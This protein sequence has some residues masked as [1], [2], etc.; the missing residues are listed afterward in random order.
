MKKCFF[1]GAT[2]QVK[3]LKEFITD[4]GYELFWLFDN[5]PQVAK[6]VENIPV[7]GG[8]EDFVGWA[9]KNKSKD[10]AFLVAIG[11]DKGKVR[12]ELQSKIQGFGFFPLTVWHK[13][14]Y[15]SSSAKID[16]GSQVLPRATVCVDVKIGKSCIIN[17][18]AQVD[19]ECIIGDG[20]HIM[21]G[22]VLTGCVRV[23]NFATIGSG[24][25]IL[26]RINIGE[27]AI[28]GA[29]AVVTKNVDPYTTV[30]GLPAKVVN[31]KIEKVD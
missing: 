14:S 23:N 8:W 2:G 31:R 5:D 27:G 11:G 18:G 7:L 1:W 19:H 28:V 29:G 21:P 3:V 6:M 17:T 9:E 13:T 4:F 24:A 15:I 26:P 25:I 22:A 10:I 20:V 30:T 12:L 16:I